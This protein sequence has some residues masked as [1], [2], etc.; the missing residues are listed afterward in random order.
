[1]E[2]VDA[3]GAGQCGAAAFVGHAVESAWGV[4]GPAKAG[5]YQPSLTRL[6]ASLSFGLASRR[7]LSRRSRA[8]AKADI[9][10]PT[11]SRKRPSANA[12]IQI[13]FDA[14]RHSACCIR[15]SYRQ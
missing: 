15:I 14:S 4:E 9:C 12:M 8:A 2:T 6:D 7:R 10:G 13:G 1:G 11:F 5:H 3:Q